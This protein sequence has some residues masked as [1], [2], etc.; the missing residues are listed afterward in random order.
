MCHTIFRPHCFPGIVRTIDLR[1]RPYA[2]ITGLAT[3]TRSL[4]CSLVLQMNAMSK[5]SVFYDAPHCTMVCPS[6]QAAVFWNRT[7][8]VEFAYIMELPENHVYKF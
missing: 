1:Y 5:Q 8:S 3:G 6:C 7:N 2:A 4:E